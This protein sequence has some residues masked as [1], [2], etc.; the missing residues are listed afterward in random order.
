MTG[1]V[2][3]RAE[4]AVRASRLVWTAMVISADY[5]AY[6][7][8]KVWYRFTHYETKFTKQISR[9]VQLKE[10]CNIWSAPNTKETPEGVEDMKGCVSYHQPFACFNIVRV[11]VRYTCRL[12]IY[13]N[14]E[15]SLLVRGS[16]DV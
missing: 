11:T 14:S 4:A 16:L 9:I 15:P 5:K 6:D 10:S 8:A 1:K 3:A 13:T 2:K 12:H 7:V